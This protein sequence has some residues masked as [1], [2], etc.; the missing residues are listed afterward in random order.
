MS[1]IVARTDRRLRPPLVYGCA[2]RMSHISRQPERV[3]FAAHDDDIDV[4]GLVP[5]RDQSVIR[6][7]GPGGVRFDSSPRE[8]RHKVAYE[9]GDRKSV[10]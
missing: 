3:R 6:D 1:N 4:F 8:W 9:I 2:G 7:I 5:R 10:V